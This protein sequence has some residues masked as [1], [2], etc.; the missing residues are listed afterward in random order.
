MKSGLDKNSENGSSRWIVLSLCAILGIGFFL[1][2][3]GLDWKPPHFDE[4][5]NG[6]FVQHVWR[7]GFYRYDPKNFHGPLYFYILLLAELI[8]GKSIVAYRFVTGLISL[9]AVA[10]VAEHRRFFGKSALWAAFILAISTGMVFYSRYAIHESL[11]IFFQVL[12]S[13]G[14]FL[15]R[16]EKSRRAIA[17]L[18]AAVV[19]MIAVKETFFIF[20]GTWFIAVATVSFR[21]RLLKRV[22]PKFSARDSVGFWRKPATSHDWI[23]GTSVGIWCLIILFT[24]FFLNPKGF[25]DMFAAFA[26]W[27]KTGTGTSGHEKPFYY[28]LELLNL[29]EWPALIALVCALPIAWFGRFQKSVVAFTAFGTWLAYSLIPYK[30]PWLILNLLWPLAFVFGFAFE[31]AAQFMWLK[32]LRVVIALIALSITLITMWRLNFKGFVNEREPYVYVQ[33]TMDLKRATDLIQARLK[34]FPEDLTMKILVLVRDP[35]PLPWIF[36]G[37]PALVY[38]RAYDADLDRG[39]VVF[40]DGNDREIV[41][42][43]LTGKYWRL[44]FKIRDSYEPGFA[45]FDFDRF[46]GFV[47]SDTPIFESSIGLEGGVR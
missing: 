12:F 27:S 21:D 2:S 6:N 43:R 3:F 44:P 29:Y 22:E 46:V 35:W 19:G 47:P 34:E 9:G 15:W 25:H 41:E 37:Y 26:F 39:A 36:S 31:A 30:T 28:W 40:I 33:S 5:I 13:F 20:I 32:R 45:Y 24:G 18:I 10:L 1:R 23:I 14:Y 17:C 7:D 4:G 42:A 38:G 11:F 8:F 16:D